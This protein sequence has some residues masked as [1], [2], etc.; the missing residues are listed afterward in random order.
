M[1]DLVTSD[2]YWLAGHCHQC[3]LP[4]SLSGDHPSHNDKGLQNIHICKSKSIY[5]MHV[6]GRTHPQLYSLSIYNP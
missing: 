4:C 3:Q 2:F 6:K 5:N 1:D